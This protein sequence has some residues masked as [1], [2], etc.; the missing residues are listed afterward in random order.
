MGYP[1]RRSGTIEHRRRPPADRKKYAV[2][3]APQKGRQAR[4]TAAGGRGGGGA[5]GRLLA[6]RF[7]ARQPAA[8]TRSGCTAPILGPPDLGDAPTAAAASCDLLS[9][10]KALHALRLGSTIRSAASGWLFEAP[11]PPIFQK[12]AWR[13][14]AGA[15][16][17]QPTMLCAPASRRKR[18]KIRLALENR[19]ANGDGGEPPRKTIGSSRSILAQFKAQQDRRERL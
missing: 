2:V 18:S 19:R 11:L 4:P 13:S 15:E 16:S 10:A 8:P 12:A 6:N 17:N 9:L 7:Q 5:A 14:C 1:G 3:R